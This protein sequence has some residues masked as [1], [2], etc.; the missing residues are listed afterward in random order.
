MKA[1]LAVMVLATS[2][3]AQGPSVPVASTCGIK[4]VNL[5]VKLDATRHT[6]AQ[7]ESGKAKVYFIQDDGPWGKYQHYVLKVALDGA[8]VGAYKKNSYFTVPVKPGEQHV[9]ATVQTNDFAE[10]VL[11]LAHFTAEPGK[12][13]YFRTRFL[14]G[15]STLYPSPPYLDLEL[16]DSDEAKYLISFY[17]LSVSS[18]KK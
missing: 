18:A 4:N 16:L 9:C 14:N 1:V 8:W 13:Y 17:P 11:A 5:A 10:S 15:T 3:L 6:P 12:V 2:A 7:P